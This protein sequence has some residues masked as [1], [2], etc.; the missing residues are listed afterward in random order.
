MLAKGITII[1]EYLPGAL[2]KEADFQSPAVRDSSEWKLDPKVFQTIC[3]KSE[4][5][6]VDLF[7]S[8]IFPIYI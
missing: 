8:R 1:A 2:N 4:L 6:D 5:P 3:S 7:A